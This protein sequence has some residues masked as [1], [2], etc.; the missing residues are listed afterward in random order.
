MFTLM[1]TIGRKTEVLPLIMDPCRKHHSDLRMEEQQEDL[2]Q[3]VGAQGSEVSDVG[4]D[5]VC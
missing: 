4:S 1:L 2:K 5:K 3:Q